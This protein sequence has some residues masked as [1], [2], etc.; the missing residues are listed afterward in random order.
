MFPVGCKEIRWN[1]NLSKVGFAYFCMNYSGIWKQAKFTWRQANFKL[2]QEKQLATIEHNLNPSFHRIL[3]LYCYY[4]YY[5]LPPWNIILTPYFTG[6]QIRYCYFCTKIIVWV[7]IYQFLVKIFIWGF[8]F[9]EENT[10]QSILPFW[11]EDLFVFRNLCWKQI[12]EK[13]FQE[14]LHYQ[15]I[16]AVY[17][18]VSSGGLL[19]HILDHVGCIFCLKSFV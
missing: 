14:L 16:F 6:I 7:W 18:H 2:W 12:W 13:N 15:H 3:L 5:I 19:L 1:V 8:W 4:R 9:S 17:M 11:R 10:E